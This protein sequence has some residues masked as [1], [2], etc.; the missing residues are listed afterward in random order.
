MEV[1]VELIFRATLEFAF[2]SGVL[3]YVIFRTDLKAKLSSLGVVS[4]VATLVFFSSWSVV[5]M[6]D[7]WQYSYPQSVSFVPLARFAMYQA[8]R[9]E[10]V[11]YSYDW[12]ATRP[13]GSTFRVNIVK[14]LG[15]GLPATSSRMNYLLEYRPLGEGGSL[16]TQ[17]QIRW[18]LRHFSKGIYDSLAAKGEDVSLIEFLRISKVKINTPEVIFSWAPG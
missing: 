7:R 3:Y 15:I 12:R 16:V 8:Q 9:P 13:N 17:D 4:L 2:V 1:T 18:E 11:E 6:V 10:S 14:I 5:Q